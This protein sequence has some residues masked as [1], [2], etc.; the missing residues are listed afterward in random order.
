MRVLKS[1]V[2]YFK[3]TEKIYW[4]LMMIIS[5][6]SLLLLKTVPTDSG[7]KSYFVTM[8]IAI[9]L[10]YFGAVIVTFIDYHDI[11]VFWY[12][13]AGFCLFL[14]VYTLK[15][16][17]AV[18]N[19]G[20]VDARAW[21]SL[22]GTSFQPSE[23]VKIGFMVTF[24]KHLSALKERDLLR[25]P[26]HVV[27]LACHALIPVVL[28][29]LQ[30]DDGAGIIFFCMFLAM[31]FGAG[32][33][34]RYFLIL[35]AAIGAAIPLAWKYVLADYQKQRM[36]V[37]YH[38]DDNYDAV[39]NY[40]WQQYQARTSIGSGGILGRGLFHSPR[41]NSKIV[42]VQEAD[43]IFSAAGEQL[44]FIGC[45]LIIL[46]LLLLLWR[47]LHIA[48]KSPDL[49]GSSIC[50][51]FFGMIA[52]QMIFNL[53]MCLDLLPVMGVT[54]PFFSAGGSSAACL[55]FG[56]GLV[57]NVYMHRTNTDRV[58]LRL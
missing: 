48:R 55:Y 24:A 37:T 57:E 53:G 19:T 32:I 3:Q 20:G 22:G 25:S 4:S 47:T 8:L 56:F 34:L 52:A 33:Q 49:L 6:F 26:V 10:G 7:R 30:G 17:L 45:C 46:L 27:L 40:G 21:I 28:V 43:L 1:F 41:V 31:A 15:F 11:A 38:L 18:T 9:M 36:L 54:L 35:F 29:H 2:N 13:V 44:G 14:I 12:I 16:G 39:M 5:A 58:T 51:G 50:M 42:P 23:L